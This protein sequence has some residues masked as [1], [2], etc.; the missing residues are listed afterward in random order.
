VRLRD[1]LFGLNARARSTAPLSALQ[2]ADM[3][4]AKWTIQGTK[5]RLRSA[6]VLTAADFRK[7]AKQLGCQPLRARKIG[8]VAARKAKKA[9]TV[10]TR[11]NGKETT[12]KA[13]RGDYVVTS[14]T[15][16]RTPLR[17]GDR[18]LNAYVIRARKFATLYE[19]TGAT[20]KLGPV[21]RAKAAVLAL[22]VRGGLDI[23]A[24]WGNRQV[25][26]DGWL[27]LSGGEVYGNN[28]QTFAATYEEVAG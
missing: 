12:N 22:R 19:A 25:V 23:L 10:E 1:E 17:D 11:W 2:Q 20:S 13:R 7:V 6:A 3:T 21:Y 14:L 27:I 8:F 15:A 5:P 16:K 9:E 28:T 24:P 4:G 18:E 26:P